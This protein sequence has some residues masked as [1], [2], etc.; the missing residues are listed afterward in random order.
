MFSGSMVA[1]VTPFSNNLVDF[2]AMRKLIER[3]IDAG[4]DGI[5]ICGST[6][7]G[8]LL[9]NNEREQII[10]TAI[11]IT[12]K[13]TKIIVGCSACGTDNAISFVKQAEKLKADGVLVVAPY[14]IKPTQQGIIEHFSRIHNDSDI[15]IIM[16]NNPGRCGVNISIDTIVALSKFARIVALKDSDTNLSRIQLI[17]AQAPTLKLLSGDDASLLGYLAHGGDG[18]ISVTAN[19]EPGLVKQ[20]TSSVI[21]GDIKIA[22]EV[23]KKLTPLSETLFVESNP[24][25]VKYALHRIGLIKNELRLPLVPATQSTTVKIDKILL[26]T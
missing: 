26:S 19:I 10:A 24:I 20:L 1:L 4:S 14:Y 9:S 3:Q 23:N 11:E 16:Y 21:A 15:P 12:K 17:K 5:L 18:C 13:K 6:G 2:C 25:P 8:L 22:Q 7:E